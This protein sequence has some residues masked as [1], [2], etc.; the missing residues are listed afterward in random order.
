MIKLS[1]TLFHHL[2]MAFAFTHG[3]SRD[4]EGNNPSDV[5]RWVSRNY[6]ALRV[7]L[8]DPLRRAYRDLAERSGFNSMEELDT[9][10]IDALNQSSYEDSDNGGIFNYIIN[11]I[12]NPYAR[13]ALGGAAIAELRQAL[14]AP[15]DLTALTA[16][17]ASKELFCINCGREFETRELVTYVI[18]MDRGGPCLYCT[19]CVFPEKIACKPGC[20]ESLDLAASKVRAILKK[21]DCTHTPSTPI[22]PGPEPIVPVGMDEARPGSAR[23]ASGRIHAE[24]PTDTLR[25][26]VNEERLRTAQRFAG[27]EQPIA[28]NAPTSPPPPRGPRVRPS[29]RDVPI[30]PPVSMDG[31]ATFTVSGSGQ[32]QFYNVASNS[33][34]NSPPTT[35]RGVWFDDTEAISPFTSA[36]GEAPDGSTE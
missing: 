3:H 6:P 20:P 32:S 13:N 29:T 2:F 26:V 7:I 8:H 15:S 35:S 30:Q 25:R 19:N 27:N 28:G 17:L 22:P 16:R 34:L 24:S 4:G 14:L 21:A 23:S 12:R 18:D 36:P 11:V 31:V 33:F 1:K 10:L 9:Q 5:G